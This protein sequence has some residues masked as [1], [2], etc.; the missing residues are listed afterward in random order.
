ML[1]HGVQ[2]GCFTAPGLA[3]LSP[4]VGVT[5]M[6]CQV[7]SAQGCEGIGALAAAGTGGAYRDW[8]PGGMKSED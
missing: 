4:E 6:V 1:P 3:S 5:T 8:R 7:Q 2:G